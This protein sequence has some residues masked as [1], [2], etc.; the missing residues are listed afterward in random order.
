MPGYRLKDPIPTSLRTSRF[1]ITTPRV[2]ICAGLFMV[3]LGTTAC[4]NVPSG[5]N[6]V[7]GAPS[8]ARK[9]GTAK[10]TFEI[11]M[12][13]SG[14]GQG[15]PEFTFTFG[16]DGAIDFKN[17]AGRI[18]LRAAPTGGSTTL[19]TETIFEGS[20]VYT[21]SPDC[22]TGALNRKPWI[23]VNASEFTGY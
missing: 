9:T 18:A 14:L 17:Q 15:V 10:T 19:G 5:L 23:K 11:A 20:T 22:P 8:K 6:L 21:K 1:W 2:R 13:T 12:S 7:A 16:G 4:R 3:L